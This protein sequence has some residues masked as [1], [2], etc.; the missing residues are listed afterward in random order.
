MRTM[1]MA[2][3]ISVVMAAPA[4]ARPSFSETSTRVTSA[5]GSEDVTSLIVAYE[6]GAAPTDGEGAV[7]GSQAVPE[8]ELVPGDAIGFGLRTVGLDD[9]MDPGTA[10]ALAEQLALSPQVAWAEPDYPVSVSTDQPSAPWGLDRIDQRGA[11]LDG[12]YGYDTGGAGVTAYIIDTGIRSTH[13][14]F[15]GR[16]R[17]GFNAVSGLTGTEDCHG[18]GTHVAGTV[19][20][21]T[22]GVAKAADLVAVRVLDCAGRGWMSDVVVGLNWVMTDHAAGVPAVVNMSIGGSYSQS[23]NTAVSAAVADGITVVVAAGNNSEDACDYSPASA[24]SAITVQASTSTDA[25]GS[26]S[27]YGTCTDLYAPGS[28]ITSA[29]FSSDTASSVMTGTSMASPHVAGVAARLLG[30]TPAMSPAQVSAA[31]DAA[32]TPMSFGKGSGDPNKLLYVDPVLAPTTPGV[33]GDLRAEPH[34]GAIEMS[35]TTPA[36]T[37]GRAISSYTAQAWTHSAGGSLVSSCQ[38]TSMVGLSCTITGLANETAYYVGSFATNSVGDG[39]S[40]SR[41]AATPTLGVLTSPRALTASALD[42]SASVSWS[43]PIS[44]GGRPISRYTAQAWPAASGG[45]RRATCQPSPLTGL[46]C[47]ITGLTNGT[48]YYV[49]AVATTSLADSAPST[50]VPVT[51]LA[52]SSSGGGSGGGSSGGG[53]GGSS[54]GGNGGSSGGGSSAAV[55][56]VRPAFGSV[57]GGTRILILGY[58]FWGARAVT[59]GGVAAP[60][61]RY[62]DAATLEVVTPPGVAGWQDVI[63]TLAVGRV[64]A[65]FNYQLGGAPISP[66]TTAPTNDASSPAVDAT[67]D[68]SA[69]TSPRITRA[70]VG[71]GTVAVAWSNA[72]RAS[73]STQFVTVFSKGKPVRTVS[74]APRASRVVLRGLA[75]NRSYTVTI[76]IVLNGGHEATSRPS[77]TIRV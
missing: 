61:F 32:S 22:Y 20:G 68:A 29:S 17:S 53:G 9:P 4:Q 43:E 59:I 5:V 71:H 76:T 10:E 27:N 26:Y 2:A 3:A 54:G 52:P 13:V 8:A 42:S 72:N 58:G 77:R 50:R 73:T 18:H 69:Q 1:V 24:G 51:P 66:S 39:L 47:T 11:A 57:A 25:R 44:S 7:T 28:S 67:T 63:V 6:P 60:E 33:P 45:T 41:I 23:V 30:V 64:T 36:S 75:G 56:E 65:G 16:V 34:D 62:V 74:V 46:A 15:G 49:D 35:W 55:L 37:G 40:T 38:P 31:I 70:A 12:T 14:D 19:A 48:T 21:T